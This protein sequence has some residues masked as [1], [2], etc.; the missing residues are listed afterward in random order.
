MVASPILISKGY[1]ITKEK[2]LH[3]LFPR[4]PF[5]NFIYAIPIINIFIKQEAKIKS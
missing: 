1:M 4:N 5:H 2:K 3:R